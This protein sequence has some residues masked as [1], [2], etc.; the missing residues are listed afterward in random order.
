MNGST[1]TNSGSLGYV[2]SDWSIAGIG[3]S[4]RWQSRHPLADST[5]GQVYLWFIN[6]TRCRA[7]G[8]SLHHLRLGPSGIGDFNG[9]G[10]ADILWRNSTTGQV[11]IWLMNGTTLTDSGSLGY[12][13]SDWSIAGVVISMATARVTFSG[14]TAPPTGLPLADQRNCDVGRWERHYVSSD[15][16]IEG[17]AT[18][19][20][21]AEP[22]FCGEHFHGA[23]LHLADETERRLT[24]SGS[25]GAPDI[26]WQITNLAQ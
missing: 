21:A 13:S 3:D 1:F 22:A 8:A 9:D 2:S 6:G 10:D 26:T 25:P 4:W 19:T 16:V 15:W 18:T 23:G 11:Y 24:S 7:A 5:T 12:V 20:A 14:A 17:W